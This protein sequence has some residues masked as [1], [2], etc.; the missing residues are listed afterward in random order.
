MMKT[1]LVV[2]AG[3][4]KAVPWT[5]PEDLPFDPANP[6][7]ALGQIP[8]EGFLAAMADGSVHRFKVD[9]ATLKA[10]ITPAGGEPIDMS[11]ITSGQ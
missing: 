8:A 3:R 2:E 1:I 7:A 9:N 4:E 6:L 5:K 10:L 11:K